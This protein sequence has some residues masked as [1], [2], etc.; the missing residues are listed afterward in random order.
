MDTRMLRLPI[1]VVAL[2][3]SCAAHCARDAASGPSGEA[4]GCV[5]TCESND[6]PR[7]VIGLIAPAGFVGD[8]ADLIVSA[9]ATV[10]GAAYTLDRHGCPELP[11]SLKCTFSL[12]TSPIDSTADIVLRTRDGGRDVRVPVKL[13]AFNACGRDIAYVTVDLAG[14]AGE[15]QIAA[16]RYVSPCNTF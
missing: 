11:S 12:T 3:A 7:L 10:S 2:S 16:T 5:N 6:W 4:G 1:V 13:S 14:D 15:P 8:E 9:T